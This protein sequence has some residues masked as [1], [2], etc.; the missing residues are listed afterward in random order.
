VTRLFL[1]LALLRQR[2]DVFHSP[3]LGPPW[4]CRSPW[5]QTLH[6]V[7]PLVFDGPELEVERGRWRRHA[8][9]YRRAD[10][11]AAVSR[12]SADVGISVL[13]LDPRRV[14]FVPHG[15]DPGFHPPAAGLSERPEHLLLVGEYPHRLR[16]M[17]RIAPWSNR[18]SMP[19]SRRRPLRS[20]SSCW[21]L[22]TTWWP[23]RV[24]Q[25]LAQ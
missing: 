18:R 17:G 4:R 25:Q 21:G 12:Y 22:R 1:P 23:S 24:R 3:A 19:S 15:V 16:V 8:D 9:R 5:V 20:G 10:G 2:A 7:I 13:G 11:I 14:E 6:D